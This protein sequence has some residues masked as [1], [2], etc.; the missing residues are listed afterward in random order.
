V[1]GPPLEACVFDPSNPYVMAPHL[2]AAA[3]ELPLTQSELEQLD[4]HAS[5]VLES[6]AAAGAIRRRGDNW[7]WV[8]RERATDLTDLRGSGGGTVQVVERTTGRLLGTVDSSRA[9][10]TVHPGAVY[11]HQGESFVVHQLDLLAAVATVDAASPPYRTMP[12]WRSNVQ[13]VEQFA[14]LPG[15][16]ADW[17]FGSVDVTEQV[18]GFFRLRLPG[19]ERLDTVPLE[20][21]ES[22]LHTSA[23]WVTIPDTT[24][25]RAGLTVELAPSA[26]HAAEHAAISLLPVFATCDRNDLGGRSALRHA[27]TNCATIFIHDSVPGGA[28]FAERAFRQHGE[29]L[30]AVRG[31]LAGCACDDGCPSCIQSPK[32]G[33]D[34]QYL[35]KRGALALLDV[36]LS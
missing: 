1:V 6:L 29:L 28:G 10:A 24:L 25:A 31:L 33:N 13:I 21:P 36:L 7:F 11:L 26:L 23:T 12:L 19:L 15:A 8:A 34:N 35:S 9:P 30:T 27:D 18:T 32:C 14:R 17:H 3:A 20:M 2:A 5:V 4:S 22:H 16:L